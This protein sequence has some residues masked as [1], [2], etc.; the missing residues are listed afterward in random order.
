MHRPARSIPRLTLAAAAV[1]LALTAYAN[2]LT[3]TY[4]PFA[5]PQD[6]P[7]PGQPPT[8]VKLI[9][10]TDQATASNSA[11]VGAAPGGP[12]S[13]TGA[14][15]ASDTRHEA[16]VTGLQPESDYYAYVESNGTA[17]AVIAFRTGV[18]LLTNGSFETWHNVSQPW[19]TEEPDG[20]HGWELF[21]WEPGTSGYANHITIEIDRNTGVPEPL[22]KHL[23]HRVSM[24]EGWRTCYGGVY[25]EVTGLV[26]GTYV[27]SGWAAWLYSGITSPSAHKVELIAK[28]GPHVPGSAP[29]GT[30]VWQQ[31]GSVS[32]L[33]WKYVQADVECATGTVTIYCN[34]RA[35]GPDGA[36][37]AH[38]D[39]VRLMAA[40][41]AS[42]SFSNFMSSYDLAGSAYDVTISYD[43][44]IP[45]TTQVQW[46]PT[47]SYGS[48]TPIDP[49]LVTHH[50]VQ[51][52]GVSPAAAPYHFRAHAT[53]PPDI[54]AFSADHTF[55]APLVAFSNIT[56]EVDPNTGTNCVVT[57]DTNYSTTSNR[58]YYR[59][60]GETG[61]AVVQAEG[62]PQPNT[63]HAAAIAGLELN[64]LYQYHV[65]SGADGIVGSTSAPD[66]TFQTPVQPGPNMLYGFA[67]VG[68]PI[69]DDGDDVSPGNDWENLMKYHHPYL[70]VLGLGFASWAEC[71]PQDPG[72][73]P[74]VYDWTAIDRAIAKAVPGKSRMGYYQMWGTN[75]SWAP[76]DTNWDK[77]EEFV[78]AQVVHINQ[79]WGEV[80]IVFENEPNISRA[81][82]GWHWADWYIHCLQHF[83]N[84]VHRANAIT[85][86]P[87]K[88]IAG[89]VSGGGAGL[90]QD[91]YARGL[92]NMSD[93]LG[94]HPYPDNIRD[95]VKV[96]DLALMHSIMESYGDGDKKIWVSEGWGSGRSAGFDRSSP[97]IEPTA[98]EIE[99]MWLGLAKGYDNLM[100]PRD[101]WDPSYLWGINFFCANDNWGAQGWR[102]RA[103]PQKDGSGNIIG[104]IVDGYWM[105][106]DIAPTFW[107]GGMYDFY[108]NSKDAL[109]LLFPG[110]GLVFMNPGFELA[111]DP[112]RAH[113]PHFWTAQ[114]DPAPTD[115][116]ALDDVIYRSGSRCLK[117]TQTSGGSSGV[118][119]LTAKRSAA[120][121]TAYR[122]RVWCRTDDVASVAG[123]FYMR[124]V[125]LD[126][127]IKS[128]ELWADD[129]TG[130]SDWTLMEVTGTAPSFTSRIETGCYIN[131]IG[132]ARFDDL[133]I[134]AAA[135]AETGIVKG[136][137]L[138]ELQRPVP[139]SIVTTTTG[140]WQ[141]VSDDNGYYEMTGVPSGTYD[142]VCRKAGYV[143]FRAKNQTVAAGKASFVMFCMGLPKPGL[144]VDSVQADSAAAQP[145]QPV[146]VTVT[147]A[148][149]GQY[150]V[151]VGDVGLFVEDGSQDA[152]GAFTIHADPYNPRTISAYTSAQ[153]VFTVTAREQAAGRTVSINAYAF[154][155][156]D[157]P[158]MLTNGGL[159]GN[160]WD[161]HWSLTASSGLTWSRETADFHSPPNS[162]KCTINR[163]DTS[164]TFNWANN[165]SAYGPN[166]P[167]VA[168]P[169]TS[170][171]L[172]CYHKDSTDLNTSILVF[173]QEY[174]YDGSRHYYNGRKFVGVPKRE[175]WADDCLIYTTGDP[176]VTQGLYT[177]NRLVASIGPATNGK[178]YGT[179][180]WDDV[181]LKE[182]GD[183]LADD[184][185][186]TGAALKLAKVCSS[187]GDALAEPEGTVVEVAGLMVTAGSESFASRVYVENT[188]RVSGALV[189]LASGPAPPRN[190]YV[191]VTGV[192]GSV[193][194]E[195]ALINATI[196]GTTSMPP[197]PPWSA[198]GRQFQQS[199]LTRGL[200]MRTWGCVTYVA[201][202][203]SYFLLDDGTGIA[204]AQGRKG[205][206]VS[207]ETVNPVTPPA[208]GQFVMVVGIS[209][210]ENGGGVPVLR[211]RDQAD[212][213]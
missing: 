57:W 103:I 197:M 9:W 135:Q 83:Y 101:H 12:W 71:Q 191:T 87:N 61:Y 152:T 80:D 15:T 94:I 188:W 140:G 116:Y 64:S 105:T 131:G 81:P 92:K 208:V 82:E 60:L 56:A 100:T 168:K 177:T 212:I 8:S 154:A 17:S 23:S 65:Q 143:P 150:P 42:V 29:N 33:G 47:A 119:Q 161:Q 207:C 142:F 67:M 88:V 198:S 75:P 7:T 189:H 122:A 111:S 53:A 115:I 211:V 128:L 123:R 78:E 46:G 158:N 178:S 171:T 35:D 149:N 130:T 201:P 180:W 108:G 182:T 4:G 48:T 144:V 45:T 200:L 79:V 30:V 97:L 59:K 99:N 89:N 2:A 183:W 3:I 136:Y 112:P 5:A 205:L 156:E 98:L 27:V 173:I 20:W 11:Y 181:Y 44:D 129:V 164:S 110:N 167:I 148:D 137:T 32:E 153:F 134:A 147:V 117:L 199:P 62:D 194:G 193:D 69:L 160:P 41:A 37:F 139:H 86:I 186:D 195:R 52:A 127:T 102:A 84:G 104:F 68:G 24:D 19:G 184:R 213:Q 170:Y 91:L 55:H 175:V 126:G 166:A 179:T 21:P 77:F 165:W 28:D 157:R 36:S 138:D 58:L 190:R 121:G 1:I 120:P 162:L 125:S 63:H 210:C 176:N 204:D 26:P 96:E 132:T 18:N 106:P 146:N 39:G 38:F 16:L 185:C 133:T 74:N 72:S 203:S 151:D 31:N 93:V 90:F 118:W 202:D 43:T 34:L 141:A 196:A 10:W 6:P 49:D 209:S 54:Q 187:L 85:G 14:D 40:Q 113:L 95:G 76:T 25:Q 163:S 155:Q 192:V 109:H 50:V 114:H 22:S 206:K 70:S 66:L 172:G 107:N 124:F 73:G 51:I 145:G 13:F 174:Y 169:N 159:D